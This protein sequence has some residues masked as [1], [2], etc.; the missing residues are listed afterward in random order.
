MERRWSVKPLVLV[1]AEV[2]FLSSALTWERGVTG[3][4]C[5]LQNR[6]FRFKSG[7]SCQWFAEGSHNGIAAV[8]KTAGPRPVRVQ[9]SHPPPKLIAEMSPNGMAAVC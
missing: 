1:T 8:P 3:E 6:R 4:H 5:R 2:R 7:R 9:I